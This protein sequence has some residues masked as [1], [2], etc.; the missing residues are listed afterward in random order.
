MIQNEICSKA[1]R[2]LGYSFSDPALLVTSLTHS[3]VA[4]SRVQ[5]NE[6]LE[7]LGDAILGMI[8]CEELYRRYEDW[9]E[10]E[11]TKV[12]SFVVSRRICAV[13]ADEIGLTELLI[14][15]NGIDNQSSLPTSLRAAVFEAAIGAI[16]LDGGIDAAREFI[17][18]VIGPQVERCAATENHD[19]HKSA[20]QQFAQRCMNSTPRYE[21]LDEQGP[22]HCKCFEVC[23][24][25]A[26]ERYPSAWGASKKE[27]EQE[28]ARRALERIRE[29]SQVIS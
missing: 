21:S 28:A 14:L 6:R 25:I 15:G 26:G 17:L 11:L 18:R 16:F 9:L 13:I 29:A 19:N 27:A 7:F 24:V 8:I 3:S 23:V 1:E 12:K 4:G 5:S 22:D 10:G 20:L 2:I